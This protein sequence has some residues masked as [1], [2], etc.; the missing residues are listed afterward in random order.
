MSYTIPL[1]CGC[2]AYVSCWPDSGVAHT[3]VIEFRAAACR[4]RSHERGAK[5]YLW[6]LLPQTRESD[7]AKLESEK[8]E[9]RI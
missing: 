2:T 6:E 7:I 3:R 9:S 8:L 4:V 1:P 5:V